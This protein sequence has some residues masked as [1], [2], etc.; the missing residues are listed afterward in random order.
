MS[1][2]CVPYFIHTSVSKGPK[3]G[4]VFHFKLFATLGCF[5]VEVCDDLHSIADIRVQG[6]MSFLYLVLNHHN[7]ILFLILS[8]NDSIVVG[9]QKLHNFFI[10]VCC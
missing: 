10:S 8:T 5:H 4:G 3:D 1:I 7:V 9:F 6:M 2:I